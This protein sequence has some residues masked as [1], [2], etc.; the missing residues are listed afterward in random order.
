MFEQRNKVVRK[1][2]NAF[3]EK[4]WIR[5]DK[6]YHLRCASAEQNVE[7]LIIE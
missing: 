7:K 6:S 2:N 3:A 1:N 4:Q 5:L